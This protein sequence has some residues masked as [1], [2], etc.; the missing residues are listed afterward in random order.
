MI[1]DCFNLNEISASANNDNNDDN[2]TSNDN[3]IG[4]VL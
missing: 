4:L 1:Y 2:N 3:I